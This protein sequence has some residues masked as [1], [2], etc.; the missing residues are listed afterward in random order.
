ML[1]YP[2][3]PYAF[4]AVTS[5]MFALP[6][7]I[8]LWRI[9]PKSTTTTYLARFFSCIVLSLLAVF[10]QTAIPAWTRPL[11]PAQDA[12]VI[13]GGVFLLRF[14]YVFPRND[15]P[16]EAQRMTLI[17]LTLV[18]AAWGTTFFYTWQFYMAR[19]WFYIADWYYALMPLAILFNVAIFLRRMVHFAP[20]ISFLRLLRRA[21]NDTASAHRNFAL[22]VLTGLLQSLGS[23]SGVGIWNLQAYIPSEMFIS[24]G[25]LL[26]LSLLIVVYLSFS[27]IQT[28]FIARLVGVALVIML[29][30]SG[31]IGTQLLATARDTYNAQQREI[32]ALTIKQLQSGEELS[33]Y[34]NDMLFIAAYDRESTQ[35]ADLYRVEYI[36]ADT[37][38]LD[39][40]TLIA[41]LPTEP[42]RDFAPNE[43]KTGL[44]ASELGTLDRYDDAQYWFF[45]S[46]DQMRVV[47]FRTLRNPTSMAINQR[48]IVQTIGGTLLI[49][50]MLPLF[51]SR[52]LVAP[53]ER[54]VKGVRAINEGDLDINVPLTIN[55]EIGFL[56]QS[57]NEMA[58]SLKELSSDLERKVAQRTVELDFARKDAERANRAKTQ[59]LANMSHELRTPLN[60]IIGYADIMQRAAPADHRPR[61]IHQSGTHLLTL[62]EDVLNIAKIETGRTTLETTSF[63]LPLFITDLTTMMQQ[64]ITHDEV[65]FQLDLASD[66]PTAVVADEKRLRQILLNLLENAAKFTDEGAVVL[67]VALDKRDETHATITFAVTDSGIGIPASEIKSILQPFYQAT[68]GQQRGGTGLGLAISQELLSLMGSQLMIESEVGVGTRIAFTL[69]LPYLKSP[70][71]A[72]ATPFRITGIV[73]AAPT[74][75]VVD[76]HASNRDV[77]H[78]LLQPIGFELHQAQN[79]ADG[80]ALA[81]THQPD[82]IIADLVM[83]VMDGYAL[84]RAVRADERINSCLLIA[85]SASVA[86]SEAETAIAAGFD[87]FLPKPI[88]SEQVLGEIGRNLNLTYR[89]DLHQAESDELPL[90]LPTPDTLAILK[91]AARR[92]D[93]R[94]LREQ[95][96]QL[97][98]TQPMLAP[99]LQ[100]LEHF[101]STFQT[102]ALYNWL[103]SLSE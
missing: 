94:E 60:A 62:I 30:I 45:D 64:R 82:V 32:L 11:W 103:S 80:L 49:L 96:T 15:Q 41:G 97:A 31:T 75:L 79:G 83:P 16:R 33:T 99:F 28:T 40:A 72:N 35:S 37:P 8:Y 52:N 102:R 92:G 14:A 77:I 7:T 69:T 98:Q 6:A 13:L 86:S 50:I 89:Y 24:L 27:A 39:V 29:I 59:F 38:D 78:D 5:L 88:D 56:T 21:P 4:I 67:Q 42:P 57:V 100:R 53:I 1:E 95:A 74:V 18:I 61:Q 44:L 22:A 93:V 54:L 73:D 20:D 68:A 87:L 26:T 66:L 47:G 3:L 23:V 43:R 12:L 85:S 58:A 34:P 46:G 9:R 91:Q 101:V 51:Y 76:D 36:S 2:F 63:H 81:Q 17:Y 65:E 25:T 90:I 70:A 55:D 48:L 71:S 19:T 10:F 84:A